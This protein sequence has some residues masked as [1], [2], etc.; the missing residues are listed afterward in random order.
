MER[1]FIC[2]F[3]EGGKMTPLY[4]FSLFS[5]SQPSKCEERRGLGLQEMRSSIFNFHFF[6]TFL[7]QPAYLRVGK[8]TLC[9]CFS[10]LSFFETWIVSLALSTVQKIRFLLCEKEI[11]SCSNREPRNVRSQATNTP[12]INHLCW[13]VISVSLSFFSL[14][15]KLYHPRVK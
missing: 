6:P 9:F 1:R 4:F 10:L 2:F 5:I 11:F 14:H 15:F 13:N 3:W 12:S 8:L 7:L